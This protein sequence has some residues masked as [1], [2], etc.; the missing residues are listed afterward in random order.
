MPVPSSISDLSTTPSLNSPAGTESPSTVDDYLRTQAAFIKQV[1][2]KATGTVKSADLAA[3]GGSALVGYDGGTVEARLMA[4][5]QVTKPESLGGDFV[6][7]VIDPGSAGAYT[8]MWGHKN[9]TLPLTDGGNFVFGGT[10]SNPHSIGA[11]SFLCTIGG[12][13]NN[14]IGA[15]A[16]ATTIAGGAH[17]TVSASAS[18]AAILGGSYQTVSGSYG[19]AVGGTG[20]TA[21]ATYSFVGGGQSNIAGDTTLP[22]I[23]TR[24]AFVGAGANNV[25]KGLRSAIVAGGTNT[26][27]GA[28]A[29]VGAGNN[30]NASGA[31]A[32]IGGGNTNTASGAA[33]V[34]PGGTSCQA[35]GADSFAGGNTSLASNSYS[36]AFGE[37][38]ES[39]GAGAWATGI[40]SKA[41]LR[42]QRSH[43]SGYFSAKGDAQISDLVL[44]GQTTSASVT[45]LGLSGTAGEKLVLPTDTTW[46]FSVM[47]VARR[48]DV[49]G[50][51]AAYKFEGCIKK[52]AG[53]A[54]T[55]IVGSV[56]KTVLA[57]STAA[58]DANV[59]ANTTNGDLQ[60]DVTG[61]AAKTICWVA[62]VQLTE[63][64]G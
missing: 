45:L 27:G 44:R 15:S 10:S 30:N 53:S 49:D 5:D 58:W 4:F 16:E 40:R 24:S 12:G 62:R 46:A 19:S 29:F 9:N 61:E 3:T 37:F 11:G 56:T 31:D 20:N 22:S 33:A 35:T 38:L 7:R 26:A 54:S 32:V 52:D 18:H 55:S 47:V 2:D 39:S 48:T 25:A 6:Q 34:V 57:E 13:Y 21:H 59:S 36:F 14:N 50:E 63:V 60:I 42:G 64:S 23:D 28:E 43:A 51:S 1:D 41:S 8:W 17:H